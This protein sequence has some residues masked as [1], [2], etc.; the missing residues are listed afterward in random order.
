MSS[1]PYVGAPDTVAPDAAAGYED[2]LVVG[3]ERRF[4]AGVAVGASWSH[5]R[6]GAALE[7]VYA[8]DHF[9]YTNPDAARRTYDGVTLTLAHHASARWT[10]FASYTYSRV[11]GNYAGVLLDDQVSLGHATRVFDVPELVEN[12]PGVLAFER[13]HY[14]KLDAAYAFPVTRRGTIV[15][16]TRGRA[17]SGTPRTPSNTNGDLLLARGSLG[18]TP[19]TFSLDLRVAYVQQLAHGV[20][21]EVFANAF[22]VLDRQ[23]AYRYDDQYAQPGYPLSSVDGGDYADLI[24]LRDARRNQAFGRVLQRYNPASAEVGARVRF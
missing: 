7:D 6:L 11:R 10:L 8:D 2:E 20:S 24:W 14:V 13:P 12:E 3:A 21:A 16:G 17:L 5:R 1:P 4:A 15:V 23:D 22:N 19:A 9:G 18:R